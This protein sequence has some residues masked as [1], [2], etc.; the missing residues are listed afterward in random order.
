M[1]QEFSR[2]TANLSFVH[3]LSSLAR[4]FKMHE[5]KEDF[6][7]YFIC[8]ARMQIGLDVRSI[9]LPQILITRNDFCPRAHFHI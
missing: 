6:R 7:E 1:Y 4:S 9:A 3:E 2:L 5:L 8:I